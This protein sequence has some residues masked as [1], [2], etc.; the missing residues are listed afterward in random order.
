MLTSIMGY[1]A[2]VLRVARIATFL[3]EVQAL[4]I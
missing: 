3:F 4:E 1:I 2:D